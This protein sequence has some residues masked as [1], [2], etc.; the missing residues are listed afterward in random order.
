MQAIGDG[1]STVDV[2]FRNERLIPTR[3]ARAADVGIGQPDVFRLTPSRKLEVLAGGFR[4]DR[5]RPE[6]IDLAEREPERLLSERG[7]PG[8]GMVRVRWFVRGSGNA[9][10]S[11][12]GEKAVDVSTPIRIP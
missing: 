8:R 5:F 10:V 7:I 12:E 6:R 11:W 2:I 4:N 1:I 9:G 3:S